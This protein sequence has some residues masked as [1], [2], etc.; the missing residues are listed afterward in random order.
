MNLR[1][2]PHIYKS[3]LLARILLLTAD[4]IAGNGPYLRRFG[5][6]PA[7]SPQPPQ[8]RKPKTAT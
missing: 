1:E 3:D 2:P 5:P 6:S 7:T 4:L 8:R